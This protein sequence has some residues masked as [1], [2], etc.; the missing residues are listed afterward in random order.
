M[1]RMERT[2]TIVEALVTWVVFSLGAAVVFYTI[3]PLL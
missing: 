3:I 1:E 2:S